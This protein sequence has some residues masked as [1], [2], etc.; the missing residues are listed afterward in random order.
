VIY[1]GDAEVQLG[2]IKLDLGAVEGSLEPW[3]LFLEHGGSPW[4]HGISS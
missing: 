3:R 1:P 4:S 2:D